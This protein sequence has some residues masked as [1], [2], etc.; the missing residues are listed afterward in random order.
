MLKAIDKIKHLDIDYICP[1]HGPVHRENISKAIELSEKYA[2]QHIKLLT[3]RNHKNILVTYISA[4]GFTSRAAELITSGILET[5][6]I[7]VDVTDIENISL[8]ELELKVMMADGILVGSPTINQNTLLPVYKLFALINPLRDKGKLAG[9]FGSFGWSGEAPKIILENL[10]LLKLKIFEETAPF[11]FSP[12][13][14]KE[15]H[16]TDFGRRFAQKFM[17]GCDQIENPGI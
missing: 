8:E 6:N 3:D 1:G 7:T 10:R 5:K 14:S 13:G 11:K 2:G 15:E 16:L 4:Y 12:E 17:E 9:S